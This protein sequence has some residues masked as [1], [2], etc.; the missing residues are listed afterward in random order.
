MNRLF[1]EIN[2]CYNLKYLEAVV[3]YKKKYLGI[4]NKMTKLNL[5]KYY[6]IKHNYIH[7]YL[8]YWHNK[9]LFLFKNFYF[10]SNF[11]HTKL[12]SLKANYTSNDRLRFYTTIYGILTLEEMILKNSGGKLMVE[13][14]LNCKNIL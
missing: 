12:K 11:K 7:I 5:I 8:R 10:K 9:P 1:S 2:N 6:T 4:L 14:R 3:K 13:I